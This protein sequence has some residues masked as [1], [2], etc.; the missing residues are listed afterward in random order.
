MPVQIESEKKA[1]NQALVESTWIFW[2]YLICPPLFSPAL[3]LWMLH[4]ELHPLECSLW[5]LEIDWTPECPLSHTGFNSE[6]VN[7]AWAKPLLGYVP[8]ALSFSAVY[9]FALT[10]DLICKPDPRTRD[11]FSA[12]PG[13]A[14][15][16]YIGAFCLTMLYYY[17]GSAMKHEINDNKQSDYAASAGIGALLFTTI[18]YVI[19]LARMLY[20][21]DKYEREFALIDNT[22][23]IAQHTMRLPLLSSAPAVVAEAAEVAPVPI[24]TAAQMQAPTQLREIA[25]DLEAQQAGRGNPRPAA[26]AS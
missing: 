25:A 18:N 6:W 17:A 22:A 2:G 16:G 26:K 14:I 8:L 24:L 7:E 12:L 23:A 21:R 11:S 20:L 1:E 15:I 5:L 19:V 9:L 3:G 4:P 13:L 10:Q